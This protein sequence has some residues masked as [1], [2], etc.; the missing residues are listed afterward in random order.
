MNLLKGRMTSIG[1]AAAILALV[2]VQAM[3]F[4]QATQK[5]DSLLPASPAPDKQAAEVSK[6]VP[7]SKS[8]D[9]NAPKPA[10]TGVSVD[11]DDD[12]EVE[13]GDEGYEDGDDD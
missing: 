12:S 11:D 4:S 13:D 6:V 9:T 1:V 8:A 10:I 7:V 2:A 5:N 3:A